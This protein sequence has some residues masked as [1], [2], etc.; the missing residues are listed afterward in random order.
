MARHAAALDQT[1]AGTG[2]MARRAAA[3]VLALL[4]CLLGLTACGSLPAKELEALGS[5]ITPQ[6][7]NFSELAVDA[8][9]ARAAYLSPAGIRAAY[10][11]TVHI[12]SPG[13]KD[14]QYFI[15]RDD[16]ARTQIITVRGTKGDV[17][18]KEDFDVKVREDRQIKIPVHS[19][20]D[21][22][23]RAIYADAAP[24][25]KKGYTTTMVGHS[26]GGAVVSLLGIYAIEDGHEV[27]KITTF[28]QPRFTTTQG[29]SQLSFLPLLR[30]VDEYDIIPLLPNAAHGKFGDYEQVGPEVI[31][32]QGPYYVYLP[33]PVAREVSVGEFWRD[34]DLVNLQDH[35]MAAYEA[36][37]STK[38]KGS[39]QVPYDVRKRYAA[40]HKTVQSLKGQ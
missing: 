14:V 20:F 12:A 28:G 21:A 34:V 7:V 25:L 30:V 31:L 10:P 1:F 26:L 6:S 40:L 11:N 16:K 19:G 17:N 37:I 38:L 23:A 22:D 27:K 4:L 15:E 36:R 24:L 29:A 3:P 35:Q 2:W 32:L 18:L 5:V 8:K 33:A 39:Q 9:R 13:G